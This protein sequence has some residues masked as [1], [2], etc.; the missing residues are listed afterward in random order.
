MIG[1][2]IELIS[3]SAMV[4][5]IAPVPKIRAAMIAIDRR[6]GFRRLPI[7]PG[8]I[9]FARVARAC[10]HQQAK[11]CDRKA[12]CQH[13]YRPSGADRWN[14]AQETGSFDHT[15]GNTERIDHQE[16]TGF[17]EYV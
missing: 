16:E 17:V 13:G 15:N 4:G 14:A 8:I 11:N 1:A 10:Q 5:A 7:D 12:F 9:S 3:G 2:I 6:K